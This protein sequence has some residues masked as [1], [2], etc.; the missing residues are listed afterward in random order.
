[1]L[2]WDKK[3]NYFLLLVTKFLIQIFVFALTSQFEVSLK[4]IKCFI[5][6]TTEKA[7]D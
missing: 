1:M 6:Q 5:F 2:K 7:V 3:K 4:T